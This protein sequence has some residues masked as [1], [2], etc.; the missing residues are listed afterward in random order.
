MGEKR[1]VAQGR[2]LIPGSAL[3][4]P[5]SVLRS[6]MESHPAV[7]SNLSRF[8]PML[9]MRMMWTNTCSARHPV[10]QRLA[11]WLLSASADI[12]SPV[13]AIDQETVAA[14]LG[15]RRSGISEVLTR[16]KTDGLVSNGRHRIMIID[17]HRLEAFACECYHQSQ[18]SRARNAYAFPA[19]TP[20]RA[21][22]VH[23][24]ID[25]YSTL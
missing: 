16:W 18:I 15:V 8:V 14:M 7:R 24:L 23:T 4:I 12:G 10:A 6:I 25:R 1:E 2:V 17:R 20:A 11:R 21:V 13:L 22:A 9:I 5:S 19:P 3:Q